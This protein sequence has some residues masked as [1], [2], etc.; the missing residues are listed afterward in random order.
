M[1]I[2]ISIFSFGMLVYDIIKILHDNGKVYNNTERDKIN[3]YIVNWIDK[4][5]NTVILTH[6]LS[7]ISNDKIFK[8]IYNKARKKELIIVMKEEN[9]FSRQILENHDIDI[10]YYK[11]TPYQDI[12]YENRFTIINW[13]T[14]MARLTVPTTDG[15][16]HINEE[17]T[18]K[19]SIYLITESLIK[20]ILLDIPKI[21]KND[22][23]QG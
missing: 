17:Y 2:I 16:Y 9:E 19:D 15:K 3:D 20:I 6:D 18:Y 8:I 21:E 12:L 11:G 23:V 1:R 4:A 10:R 22:N 7:W 14:Q 13:G 5:G